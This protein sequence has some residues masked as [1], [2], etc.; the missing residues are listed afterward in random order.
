M[1]ELLCVMAIIAALVTLSLP[2]Y[3]NYRDKMD[4][5]KCST[6]LRNIGV[7]LHSCVGQNDGVYPEIEPDPAHPIYPPD[8]QAK[9]LLETLMPFGLTQDAVKCPA[10]LRTF[11]WYAQRFSSYEWAPYVD[12]EQQAAPQIFTRRGQFSVPLSR[13]I[14]CFD[15][16]RVHGLKS[17]FRSKKNY[18]YADGHVKPYWETAPRPRPAN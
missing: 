9:G 3:S 10:D 12:D 8:S 2:A 4:G 16:E 14:V 13:L 17:D 6:N 5:T 18:L 1:V 7:A 15:T 11:N